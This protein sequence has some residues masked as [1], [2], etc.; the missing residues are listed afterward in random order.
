MIKKILIKHL[1]DKC[2]RCNGKFDLCCYDFHHRDPNEKEFDPCASN[3][4]NKSWDVVKQE[5]DKCDLLCA[6]CHRFTHHNW[7][8]NS[9]V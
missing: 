5:L 1:G 3:L 9:G 7:E 4:A 6:N 2:K 8:T